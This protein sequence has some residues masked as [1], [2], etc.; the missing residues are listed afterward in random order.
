M[1]KI[2]NN[3][4][5][6]NQIFKNNPPILLILKSEVK[7]FKSIISLGIIFTKITIKKTLT[8]NYE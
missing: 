6:T 8:I 4:R 1:K 7:R 5:K 3:P 2:K